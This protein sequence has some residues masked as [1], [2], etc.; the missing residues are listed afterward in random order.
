MCPEFYPLPVAAPGYYQ[1]TGETLKFVGCVPRLACPGGVANVTNS[2]ALSLELFV[3]GEDPLSLVQ[4]NSSNLQTVGCRRCVSCVICLHLFRFTDGFCDLH[5]FSTRPS[6][7]HK[8]LALLV[9]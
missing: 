9:R 4:L 5:S 7:Q 2:S 1:A 6:A 8:C 3:V